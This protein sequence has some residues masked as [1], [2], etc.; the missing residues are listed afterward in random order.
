MPLS[1]N[2]Q[3]R[4]KQLANLRKPGAPIHGAYSAA[5]LEPA[6]ERHQ[7]NLVKTFP[8]ALPTEIAIL[9]ERLAQ[10]ELLGS[11]LDERGVIAHRRRGTV[12]PAAAFAEKL[13][14][15]AERQLAVL[16]ARENDSRTGSQLDTL[17]AEGRR[18]REAKF[19]ESS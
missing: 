3:A 13:A 5:A 1:Q 2:D 18:L 17:A 11:F 7:T 10:L 9:A 14:A 12:V 19:G 8:H 15:A 6:R 16:L 4:A